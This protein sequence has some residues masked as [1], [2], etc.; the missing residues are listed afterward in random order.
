MYW[1]ILFYFL[2]IILFVD[3][4]GVPFFNSFLI[5]IA[6]GIF[7][8]YNQFM[9]KVKMF[10]LLLIMWH[11]DKIHK[12]LMWHKDKIQIHSVHLDIYITEQKLKFNKTARNLQFSTKIK[13]Q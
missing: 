10:I 8:K 4:I 12:G 7:S 13:I 9:K 3:Y 11:R 5:N 2:F 6:F 1:L